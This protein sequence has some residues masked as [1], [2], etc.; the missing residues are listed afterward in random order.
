MT[1]YGA[2]LGSLV[3]PGSK[4]AAHKRQ[5]DKWWCPECKI[6]ITSSIDPIDCAQCGAAVSIA[7]QSVLE[8]S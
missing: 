5:H 6:V 8:Q 4:H 2:N 7:P 3:L 1:L